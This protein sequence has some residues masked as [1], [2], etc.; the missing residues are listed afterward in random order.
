MHP[1]Y[2]LTNLPNFD[3]KLDS[4]Y[5]KYNL[6][7]FADRKIIIAKNDSSVSTFGAPVGVILD[8][9]NNVIGFKTLLGDR[10]YN[11]SLK[12]Y[13]DYTS[14][15]YMK[16]T[17]SGHF[18][19]KTPSVKSWTTPQRERL[20]GIDTKSHKFD[21][22]AAKLLF[23]DNIKVANGSIYDGMIDF[24]DSVLDKIT[25][26]LYK[27]FKLENDHKVIGLKVYEKY[28][29]YSDRYA[30]GELK[31]ANYVLAYTNIGYVIL[32]LNYYLI[33][34]VKYSDEKLIVQSV[35]FYF[36]LDENGDATFVI[37]KNTENGYK[38]WR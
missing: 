38:F 1:Y 3:F 25:S 24:Q 17:L 21:Y 27:Q 14:K 4:I 22:Q 12:D 8:S 18:D 30:T 15:Y 2:D 36:T 6:E 19:I 13:L 29:I 37:N 10:L 20:F 9:R 23:G 26:D 31:R 32:Q 34:K 11:L 28:P 33:K 35:P 5:E 7:K 16:T